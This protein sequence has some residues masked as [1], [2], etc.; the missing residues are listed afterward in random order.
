MQTETRLP[1]PAT[2]AECLTFNLPIMCGFSSDFRPSAFL[3]FVACI[4]N[5]EPS[6][7]LSNQ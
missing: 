2:L 3:P 6:S 1:G 5:V 4:V 7:T